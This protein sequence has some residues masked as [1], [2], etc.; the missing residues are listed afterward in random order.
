MCHGGEL[1]AYGE[2]GAVLEFARNQAAQKARGLAHPQL[3]LGAIEHGIAH[4]GQ[5]GLKKEGEC[6][7]AAAALDT[8]KALVHI[9]F[10]QRATKKVRGVTDVAPAAHV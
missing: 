9:F 8:H 4:G 3:C 10:A 2:A 6:F 1:E 5:A 7:A